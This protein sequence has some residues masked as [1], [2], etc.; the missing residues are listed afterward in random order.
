MAEMFETDVTD[1]SFFTADTDLSGKQYFIVKRTDTGV[2]LCTSA[3][4][5]FGVLVNKPKQGQAAKVRVK[6]MSRVKVTAAGL[7][8][9]ALFTADDNGRA[10]AVSADHGV[11]LGECHVAGPSALDGLAT[12]SVEGGIKHTISATS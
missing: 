11:Y 2:A 5:P 10:V 8:R 6:G 4:E 12:V 9:G 7:A 3:D 1:Y